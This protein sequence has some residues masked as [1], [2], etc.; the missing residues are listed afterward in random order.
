MTEGAY[1][2]C[3]TAAPTS[4]AKN[5]CPGLLSNMPEAGKSLQVLVLQHTGS[6]MFHAA[7]PAAEDCSLAIVG[8]VSL[9]AM[10]PD[11]SL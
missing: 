5:L 6:S 2:E 4:S 10:I 8:G 7:E 11:I 1:A 3:V 9:A